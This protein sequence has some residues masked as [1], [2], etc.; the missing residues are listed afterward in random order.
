M[1]KINL[2]G[3]AP[4]PI[5][6]VT[7][8]P[9]TKAFQALTFVGA[10]IVSFA[11]VGIIYKIWSNQIA[12]LEKKSKQEKIRQTELAMV[13]SQNE[14]YQQHLKDLETRINTIQALQTS[15]VGPVEMMTALGDVINR[16]SDVYLYTVSPTADRLVL[17]GQSGTVES[18]AN[19][20]A[21][22][23]RS[24][25]FDDVQLQQFYQDDQHNRLTYKFTLDCLV[26]SPTATVAATPQPAAQRV[27]APP[28]PVAR[29]TVHLQ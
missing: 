8:P 14:R 11:I 23:K 18:L 6:A 25:Y 19:L 7:G 17:K 1:I 15:R 9:A 10:V 20:L 3:V 4:P 27:E 12:E 13:K 2:L 22:M 26:K 21:Y 28:G 16:T 29:P 5:K 24:G